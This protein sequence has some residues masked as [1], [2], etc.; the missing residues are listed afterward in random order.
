M[1]TILRRGHTL[2]ICP[3][4][5]CICEV[6]EVVLVGHGDDECLLSSP[7]KDHRSGV[8][9]VRLS[10]ESSCNKQHE[11]LDDIVSNC[12]AASRSV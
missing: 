3:P 4:R 12:G 2:P 11:M 5:A 8:R 9:F 1:R 6:A 7:E 10:P